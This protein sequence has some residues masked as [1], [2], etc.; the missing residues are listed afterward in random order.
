MTGRTEIS[1]W[2]QARV[3]GIPRDGLG[4]DWR[5]GKSASTHWQVEM[6]PSSKEEAGSERTMHALRSWSHPPLGNTRGT[7][8]PHGFR[9][10]VLAGTGTGQHSGTREL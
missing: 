4:G 5:T 6:P 1:G 3:P 9:V 10:R 7:G 8:N 2:R